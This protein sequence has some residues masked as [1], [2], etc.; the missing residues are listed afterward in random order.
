MREGIRKRVFPEI[1]TN[2]W[3]KEAAKI[4]SHLGWARSSQLQPLGLSS[5][6]LIGRLAGL[7]HVSASGYAFQLPD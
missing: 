4:I 7:K 6:G 3:W 1:L 2:S 5:C